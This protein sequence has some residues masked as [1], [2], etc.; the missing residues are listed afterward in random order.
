[1]KN[2]KLKYYKISFGDLRCLPYYELNE[3]GYL[4]NYDRENGTSKIN[5]KN[6]ILLEEDFE[7]ILGLYKRMHIL[8]AKKFSELITPIFDKYYPQDKNTRKKL[9]NI[10]IKGMNED[11]LREYNISKKA[12]NLS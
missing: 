4:I 9:E 10:L 6:V 3:Y 1:M 5:K 2:N 12:D 11:E 7:L 8:G